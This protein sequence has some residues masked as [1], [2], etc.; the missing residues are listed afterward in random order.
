MSIHL[1]DV[2]VTEF[3]DDVHAVFQSKG[4]LIK[5]FIRVKDK[6]VGE[7]VQFPVQ[8]KGLAN[9]KASQDDVQPMNL[10]YDPVTVN[11]QPWEAPEYTDVFDQASI[12]W[13]DRM[14]LVEASGMAVGRRCDQMIIDACDANP[15]TTVVDGGTN[16]T[17]AKFLDGFANLRRSA[18][19]SEMCCII[20]ADAEQSLMLQ[21]QLTQ[22]FYIDRKPLTADGFQ[23][24]TIMGVTFVV[25]PD[26]DEGG[27]PVAGNIHSAFMINKRAV[28]MGI[29][30][31]FKTEIN[32]IAHKTSWLVN[33]LFK[34]NAVVIDNTGVVQ[35]DYD[36]TA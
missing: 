1:S 31:G 27:L 35:I 18:A 36:V 19:A 12:N 33:S 20:D 25:V 34:A 17:Y 8:G 29:S 3:E 30:L 26:N 15:G 21:A 11:L 7:T 22:S 6:V 32:Y 13:D 14:E 5:P 28:G 24:M 9:Q 16:F 4:F 23:M 10:N 2:F